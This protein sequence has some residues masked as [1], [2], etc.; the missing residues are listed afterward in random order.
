MTKLKLTL[1]SSGIIFLT[2]A[3]IIL[4]TPASLVLAGCQFARVDCTF[5]RVD[6]S[7]W[8]G[9]ASNGLVSSS[10][11]GLAIDSLTWS[12]SSGLGSGIGPHVSLRVEDSAGFAT[13]QVYQAGEQLGVHQLQGDYRVS[14]PNYSFDTTLLVESAVWDLDM[15]IEALVGRVLITDL[16]VNAGEFSLDLGD[17]AGELSANDGALVIAPTSV[18]S[19]YEI[20]GECELRGNR[21]RC[22]LIVGAQ[23]V[24]DERIHDGL[25]LIG[26]RTGPGIYALSLSGAI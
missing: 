4:Q 12:I 15:R 1:L 8:S 24:N 17:F 2:A 21:Y 16:T 11:Y 25:A 22:N 6:G 19:L 9:A 10:G 5:Q 3:F 18:E 23:Q 13:A 7:L 20:D 26:R 14:Q